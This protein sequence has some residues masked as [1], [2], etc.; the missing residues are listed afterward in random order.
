MH[1]NEALVKICQDIAQEGLTP[2]VGL[3]RARAPFK[4][5]IAQAI[6]AIKSYKQGRAVRSAASSVA[7][8]PQTLEARVAMLEKRIDELETLLQKALTTRSG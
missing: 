5:S 6:D 3:L 2:G 4:I 7:E 8:Q 1:Q